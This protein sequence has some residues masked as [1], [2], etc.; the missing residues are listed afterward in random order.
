MF[1]IVILFCE[2]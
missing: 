1:L 2:V